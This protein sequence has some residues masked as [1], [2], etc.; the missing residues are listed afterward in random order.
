MGLLWA[1]TGFFDSFVSYEC[2][3]YVTDYSLTKTFFTM[4]IR[5]K[6]EI[7]DSIYTNPTFVSL[8]DAQPSKMTLE[9]L[10]KFFDDLSF[11]IQKS[12]IRNISLEQYYTKTQK[13]LQQVIR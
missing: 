10:W 12:Q 13:F 5:T 7:V 8:L 9:D 11:A 1:I 6:N 2:F 4:N 3:L